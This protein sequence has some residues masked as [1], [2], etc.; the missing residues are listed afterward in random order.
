MLFVRTRVPIHV[1]VN[2]MRFQGSGLGEHL[3]AR[4]TG[5]RFYPRMCPHVHSQAAGFREGIATRMADMW[6]LSRMCTHVP[7]HLARLRVHPVTIS[8]SA[9]EWLLPCMHSH[10]G[11]EIAGLGEGLPT[12]RM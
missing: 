10:V 9:S 4:I 7:G 8:V 6:L 11:S 2:D 1:I 5:I 3:A 12:V